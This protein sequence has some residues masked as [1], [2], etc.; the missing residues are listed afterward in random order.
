MS[1]LT[2]DETTATAKDAYEDEIEQAAADYE[3]A[4]ERAEQYHDEP[5]TRENLI[6]IANQRYDRAMR[7]AKRRLVEPERKPAK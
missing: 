6:Y 5:D 2:T 3:A 4:L 7:E 1:N